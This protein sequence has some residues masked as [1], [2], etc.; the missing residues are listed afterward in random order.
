MQLNICNVMMNNYDQLTAVA[1]VFYVQAIS[2]FTFLYLL[3]RA[4]TL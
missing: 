1:R 4:K 2:N 3:V